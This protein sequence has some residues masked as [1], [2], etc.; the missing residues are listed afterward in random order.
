MSF[1]DDTKNVGLLLLIIALFGVIL[2]AVALFALDDYKDLD[3]W[4]KIVALVGSVI[5]AAIYAILGLGIMKGQCMIQIGGL[6]SDVKSKFGV[7]V[8]GTAGVGISELVEGI[9]SIIAYGATNA[10]TIVI[11]VLLLVMAWLMVDGG[12]L[13]GNIIWIVLLIIYI[14]G[15]IFSIIAI[16]ALI[17]IPLL[18]LFIMLLLFLLS[19]EVKSRMGI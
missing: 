13:A 12:K 15:I 18:L 7:L 14:L 9:F 19:P 3:M 11:A 5:G 17:G 2:S 8:A 10:G 6:F 16:L 4:K 1:F